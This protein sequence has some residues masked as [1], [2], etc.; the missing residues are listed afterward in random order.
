MPALACVLVLF[1]QLAGAH[2]HLCL[3][4][5]EAPIS[6]HLAAA[7]A[8]G[9]HHDDHHDDDTHTD[10]DLAWA[11]AAPAKPHAAVSGTPPELAAPWRLPPALAAPG[12]RTCAQAVP[13]PAF[14]RPHLRPPLRAP[15]PLPA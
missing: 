6:A 14:A 8:H 10:V 5:G 9:E 12:P 7:P 1:A 11:G 2:L 4:G 15:P 3:D 13:A